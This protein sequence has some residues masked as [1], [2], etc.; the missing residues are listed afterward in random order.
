[1]YL[2]NLLTLLLLLA[3]K[4]VYGSLRSTDLNQI[5]RRGSNV[6]DRDGLTDMSLLHYAAKGGALAGPLVAGQT[7]T[8]LLDRGADLRLRCRWTDMTALH[9]AV[10]FDV[11]NVVEVTKRR[12]KN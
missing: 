4:Y 9:Y 11:P 5:L 3:K 12:F 7:V 10:F 1:M 6:N 2:S 8:A